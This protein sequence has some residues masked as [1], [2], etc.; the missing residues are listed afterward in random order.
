MFNIPELIL[1]TGR[2]YDK[3]GNMNNWWT[4]ESS[5]NFE[6]ET[7]CFISFYSNFTV[8]GTHVSIE[9]LTTLNGC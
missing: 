6:D 5:V 7:K 8:D 1:L 4:D 2:Y 9:H 3:N